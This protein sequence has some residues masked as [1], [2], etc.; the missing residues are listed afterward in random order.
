MIERKRRNV[1]VLDSFLHAWDVTEFLKSKGL[2]PKLVA[3][4]AVQL[5]PEECDEEQLQ[6]LT[7]EFRRETVIVDRRVRKAIIGDE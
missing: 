1:A 5:P 7:G 4:F 6:I 3:K 2:H